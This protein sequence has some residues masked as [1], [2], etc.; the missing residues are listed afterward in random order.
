MKPLVDDAKI[1]NA[2]FDATKPGSPE[3]KAALEPI[4]ANSAKQKPIQDQVKEVGSKTQAYQEI[5][6]LVGRIVLALLVIMGIGRRLLLRLLQ[7]PGLIILPLTYFMLYKQ[8]A[9]VFCWGIAAAGFVTM[10]QLSF[11]GE[12]LPKVFPI[13][14]RGTGGSFATNVGGRMIGTSAAFLVAQIAPLFKG[15]PYDQMAQA[16]GCV[17]LG[18]VVIGFILGMFLPEPKEQAA[19]F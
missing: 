7:A 4:K 14:L 15:S 9:G 8:D 2:A 3:R 10:S 19:D 1:L 11:L 12:Y 6:G 5:G 16:A 17:G 13:H 18:A